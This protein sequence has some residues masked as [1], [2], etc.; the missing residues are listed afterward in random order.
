MPRTAAAS[1]TEPT[2]PCRTS[3]YSTPSSRSLLSAGVSFM[4][5][6]YGAADEG[7]AP[8]PRNRGPEFITTFRSQAPV[9]GRPGFTG[10]GVGVGVTVGV[11]VGVT[12]GVG[13]GAPHTG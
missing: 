5:R 9:L 13:V 2:G 1:A 4:G 10:V 12:V 3:V 11:G 8:I 7:W 6:V